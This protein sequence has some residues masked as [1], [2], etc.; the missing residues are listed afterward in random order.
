VIGRCFEGIPDQ[1]RRQVLTDNAAKL[2]K[3]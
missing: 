3:L 1:E 2:Y